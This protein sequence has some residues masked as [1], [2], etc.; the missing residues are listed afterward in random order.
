MTRLT[1]K[2]AIVTGAAN[3]IGLACARRL[4]ADGAGVALADI[5]WSLDLHRAIRSVVESSW[6][7]T[8]ATQQLALRVRRQ[9]SAQFPTWGPATDSENGYAA[10]DAAMAENW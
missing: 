6:F 2:A 8:S 5:R 3:G 9:S 1:G 10:S 4:A 7:G